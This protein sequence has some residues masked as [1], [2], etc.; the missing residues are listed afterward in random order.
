LIIS[1]GVVKIADCA[2]S[3]SL[4]QGSIFGAVVLPFLGHS[5]LARCRD[6]DIGRAWED[7]HVGTDERISRLDIARFASF[8]V[9]D[10]LFFTVGRGAP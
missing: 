10:W 3:A 4:S 9:S 5:D 7:A 6:G 2:T 8:S 1:N